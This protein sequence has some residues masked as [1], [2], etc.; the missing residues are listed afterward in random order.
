[1]AIK[2]LELPEGA[3]RF[4]SQMGRSDT[5]PED[6][7]QPIQLQLDRL[8]WVDGAYDKWGAYWG[9]SDKNHI[10]CAWDP[11]GETY[12]F[13]RA[14]GTADAVAQVCAIVPGAASFPMVEPMD[15]FTRAYIEAML[16]SSSDESDNKK[17][18]AQDAGYE[19]EE[20]TNGQGDWYFYNDSRQM[21]HSP[22]F[23]FESEAWEA[24][25]EHLGGGSDD[26]NLLTNYSSD[27]LAPETRDKIIEECA[28]FQKENAEWL[29]TEFKSGRLPIAVQAGHDFW[30]TRAETGVGFNDGDWAEPAAEKLTDAAH[31]FGHVD[32][33][34]HEGQIYCQ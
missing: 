7:S 15:E 8:E 18:A 30:L 20:E 22:Y 11:E 4:G 33:Y 26:T 24:A 27:D 14:T 13:V 31:A 34:A 1:M 5:L 9:G 19:V 3:S 6:P 12:V 2:Q 10:F 25:F 21:T 29:T 28:K 16:W 32:V 23:K 17:R